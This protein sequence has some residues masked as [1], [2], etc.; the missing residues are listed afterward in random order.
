MGEMLAELVGAG[1]CS[2]A[3]I[4]ASIEQRK[5]MW[6]LRESFAEALR[7]EGAGFAFDISV[8][9]ARIPEFIAR[10]DAAVEALL[11]GVVAVGFGHAGDGNVHYNLGPPPGMAPDQLMAIAGELSRTVHD[12]V[13][14][15]GGSISAEHGI[16][17]QRAGELA[18]YKDDL[19]LSMMRGIK[20]S[21][22]PENLMNPGVIL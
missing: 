15:L 20:A 7:A 11:P 4:P 12:I 9:V 3:A 16:G 21:L 19:S 13:V 2:D 22:D 18:H 5:A 6:K 17:R 14:G 1:R 10:A 8:P